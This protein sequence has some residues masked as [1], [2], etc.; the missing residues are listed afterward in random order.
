GD[1]RSPCPALNSLANHGI[2]PRDGKNLTVPLLVARMNA[3]LNI[4]NELGTIVASAAL[5]TSSNPASGTLNLD[6]LKKHGFIE[7]DGSLSRRDT[8]LNGEEQ[9][10]SPVIF[11]EFLG[12]FSGATDITFALAAKARWGRIQTERARNPEF[13]Y[14]P[15]ARFNSY[16]ESSIYLQLLR[17]AE[18]GTV[19]LAFIKIFFSQERL[20]YD[21][22]WRPVNN[23]NGFTLASDILQLSLNTPEEGPEDE[24]HGLGFHGITLQDLSRADTL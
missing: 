9:D 10:F 19:P 17:K 7:H 14:G 20:P 4:S 13:T 8:A 22:G 2:L 24:V 15:A 23:Q 12:Y 11:E 21:E 5:L 16:V 6:D 18:T 3:A 1:V